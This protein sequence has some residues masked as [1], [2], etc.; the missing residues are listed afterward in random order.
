M[1]TPH[2]TYQPR[3]TLR[4]ASVLALM[5][6]SSLVA[7]ASPA[8]PGTT[9]ATPF[10]DGARPPSPRRTRCESSTRPSR[11]SRRTWS[12]GWPVK[13]FDRQHPCGRSS[14]TRGSAR[15]AVRPSTSASTSRSQ[16]AL[17]STRSRPAP[18]GS[19]IRRRSPSSRPTA[20]TASATGTCP[21]RQEPPARRP[22]SADRLRR[23]GLG[24]RPLRRAARRGVRQPAA[25][26]RPRPVHR[27]HRPDGRRRLTSTAPRRGRR[28][29]HARPEGPRRVGATR[30]SPR[31][32]SAGGSSAAR[33]SWQT[34]VDFRSEMLDSAELH[35]RSTRR[36]RGRTTRASPAASASTSPARGAPPPARSSRSRSVTPP[37]TSPSTRRGS[38]RSTPDCDRYE[39]YL[40][41]P[42]S[43]RHGPIRP[44]SVP[45]ATVRASRCANAS[46]ICLHYGY[47]RVAPHQT[48]ALPA[49][50]RR[51]VLRPCARARCSSPSARRHTAAL[52]LTARNTGRRYAGDRAL[53]ATVSPR[54]A[55]PGHRRSPLLA[56][57]AGDRD[58]RGRPHRQAG[59][60]CRRGGLPPAS[61]RERTS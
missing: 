10:V 55:R 28:V 31:R 49:I 45:V 42:R 19:T 60:E 39:S 57:P 27:P 20:P 38:P 43:G 44:C 13:P 26:R 3:K 47:E 2:T 6:L 34:A 30:P 23:Q 17:P 59:N 1:R 58:A 56:E 29:R 46:V 25:E 8:A 11:R 18:S 5:I 24:P 50:R 21:G 35:A 61:R 51:R 12:Y 37:A 40:T 48:L 53:F 16:T 9:P 41:S 14:T 33:P 22:S 7:S 54:R 15:A 4:T 36:R 32:S 52:A